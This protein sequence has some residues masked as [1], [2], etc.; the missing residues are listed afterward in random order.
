MKKFIAVLMSLSIFGFAGTAFASG[1]YPN[2]YL[3][4]SQCHVPPD[5]GVY[6]EDDTTLLGCITMQAWNDAM[7]EQ[8]ARNSENLPHLAPGGRVTDEHGI[9]YDCPSFI[10]QG[11]VNITGTKWYVDDLN[12]IAQT[13]IAIY[14]GKANAE[15][16]APRFSGWIAAQ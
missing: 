10:S 6:S 9:V 1:M 8:A 15:A 7:T 4:A 14:G 3:P 12:G 5:H 13:L 11:C 2:G 16:N